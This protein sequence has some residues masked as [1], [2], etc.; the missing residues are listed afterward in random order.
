MAIAFVFIILVIAII[1]FVTEALPM[2]MV[3]I[4]MLLALTLGR[5]I[6]PAEAFL[7]FGD[8]VII[9]LT[10]FFIISA[11]L[12]NTGVVEAI[13]H[14]LH[15]LAG[16]GE[17]RLLVVM[18]LTAATI[19]A[20]ISNVVT[21]AVL[22]PGVIAIAKRI[23]APASSFLMPLAFGAILGGK[24]TLAGSPTNL[25]V[26]GLMP[27]YGLAPFGLFEFA[28][29]GVPIVVTGVIYMVLLGSRLLPRRMNG[30]GAEGRAEKDYLTELVVP[31]GSP[32]IGR[33]LAEADFR[34][35]YDLHIIG[36]VRGSERV[37]P[38]GEAILRPSDV[39]LVRGKPDKILSARDS[40]GLVI[41]SDTMSAH[42][43][44]PGAI[45]QNGGQNGG[46]DGWHDGR[47]DGKEDAEMSIVEAIIAPNST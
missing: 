30:L 7:G 16:D 14:K 31:H 47:L 18:M 29:I 10:S 23:K 37:L 42:E 44:H 32:L 11:A 9:T 15:R 27:R 26:N 45:L 25:A 8:P 24:S 36:I 6:T 20:F 39:L 13:G 28:P 35:K 46:Q 2:E 4:L 19:A 22:M 3:A 34:G 33:T 41:K 43:T 5:V 17:V 38:H 1:L 40:Q 21:T 12:F